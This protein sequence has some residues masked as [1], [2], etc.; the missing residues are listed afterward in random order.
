MK[1]FVLNSY[2]PPDALRLADVDTPRPAPGEV[3]VRVRATSV[4]P[5]D[6]HLMRGEP[7]VARLMGGPLGLRRPKVGVLGADVAG[8]VE[9]VG[10][11]VTG[12]RP[13]DEV[14]GMTMGGGF[15]EYARVPAD[16]LAPKPPSLSFEQAAAVP[17][18]A[19]TALIAVRDEGGVQP[20]QRVLVNG[21]SGGVGTFAVQIAKALGAEVTAVCGPRNVDLVRSLGADRVVDY[22]AEDFTRGTRRYDVLLD[23]AGSRP[24]SACRRVLARTGV[25]VLVGGPGGRWLRPVDHMIAAMAAAPFTPQRVAKVD[26]LNRPGTRQ[27]LETLTAFIEDGRVTPVI[28]RGYPFADIPEAVRY[29]E[30]GHAAGKVVVTV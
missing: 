24:P 25:L 10:A 6:W 30:R 19:G 18:A 2:G 11:G 9:D 26:V 7:Y 29:Q 23:I 28:D 15:A 13:G 4:Q 12:F 5:A 21:A 8:T 20:G 27:N 14:Y 16:R 22:S 1:A 3:L 17:L